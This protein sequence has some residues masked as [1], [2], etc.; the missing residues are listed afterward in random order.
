M[1]FKSSNAMDER[2]RF[3]VAASRREQSIKSLC[4]EF[5]ISRQTGYHWL[6]RYREV[7]NVK[8]M[9]ERSRR[10]LHS[11]NR[12][13]EDLINRIVSFRLAH[14]WGG[15]KL[16]RLL[17]EDGIE[18]S[19]STVN[20]TLHRCGLTGYKQV[21]GTAPRRF[22]REHPNDLWQMDFKGDYPLGRGR[23][24]P[25][26]VIDDHSRFALGVFALDNQRGDSVHDCLVSI[27]ER[28]GV[29]DAMLIDHGIPWYSANGNGLT[30][31]AVALIKQGIKLCFSGLRHPQTQGKV[32]RFHRTLSDSIRHRGRPATLAEWQYALHDFVSEYN[33]LRPHEA[34]QMQPPASRYQPSCRPYLTQPPEWEYI[35]GAP[36]LRLNTQGV[37]TWKGQRHFVSEALAKER[38]QVHSIEHLL[39]V[40][41]RH[42]WIREINLK[43]GRSQTMID[44]TQN[45]YV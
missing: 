16:Q 20:R 45:L 23:C 21:A 42:M 29:P 43:T 34:L 38:V 10:P 5:G 1:P 40:K 39:V 25:L 12:I 32:E 6:R 15:R 7:G 11:P 13:S 24:Y 31:L 14:G 33:H 2:I 41:F 22:E 9:G 44:K 28:C 17:A 26:S 35:G 3:V 37:L 8:Q 27:F 18:V 4:E 19:E 36:V 30:W